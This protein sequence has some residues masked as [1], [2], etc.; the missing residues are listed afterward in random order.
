MKQ[1][2]IVLLVA[3]CAV[4]LLLAGGGLA[5][6]VGAADGAYGEVILFSEVLSL[7]MENYVDPVDADGLL[8]GAYEAMLSSLDAQGAFF[9]PEEVAEWKRG[10]PQGVADPGISV[11][12][13]HASFLVVFVAPGSPAEEGGLVSGDQIRQIEGRPVRNLS[14]GQALRLLHGEPG[15]TVA[16]EILHPHRNFEL[17]NLVLDRVARAFPPYEL[18]VEQGIALLTVREFRRLAVEELVGELDDVR[19]RDVNRLMVDLRNVADGTPRDAVSFIGL[20]ASGPLLHLKDRAGRLLETL[21]GSREEPAWKGALAFLVNGA[22]A[23]GAE[24]AA[25]LLQSRRE[26][27]VYGVKTYGLGSEAKLFELPDGSGLLFS[28]GLWETSGGKTWNEGGVRGS[29]RQASS[30]ASSASR[31]ALPPSSVQPASVACKT[32]RSTTTIAVPADIL[33]AVKSTRLAPMSHFPFSVEKTAGS[34]M[35]QSGPRACNWAIS[36]CASSTL[37]AV[38]DALSMACR[39]PDPPSSQPVNPRHDSSRGVQ[40]AS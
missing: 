15:T 22:T 34:V 10:D 11:V 9:T 24:A 32:A 13:V 16:L 35:N 39:A 20:F 27:K 3:S 12:K 31:W 21:D 38:G 33:A 37:T 29:C 8:E 23:G 7:I 4:I 26:A 17:E 2:R 1:T 30:W 40:G 18:R 25:K 5:L 19:S 6:K 28:T 14:L 36:S